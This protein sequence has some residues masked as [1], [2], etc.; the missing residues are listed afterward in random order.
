[1]AFVSITEASFEVRPDES[2]SS[3]SADD[4]STSIHRTRS[5]RIASLPLRY[6]DND[7]GSF[8]STAHSTLNQPN[9]ELSPI[10]SDDVSAS[11]LN[12]ACN[13]CQTLDNSQVDSTRLANI[14][15]TNRVVDRN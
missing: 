14:S 12:C 8:S 3:S 15:T 1:M 10:I 11:A 4:V 2:N 5:Q 6:R 13:I 9:P 7:N